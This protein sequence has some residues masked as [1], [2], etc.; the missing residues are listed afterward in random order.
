MKTPAKTAV[1]AVP[2]DITTMTGGYIYDRLLLDELR[3]AGRDMRLLQLPDGFPFPSRQDMED[4]LAALQAIDR[5]CPVIID[6]LAFGALTPEGVAR[7]AAPIVALVHHP[8]ALES[9]LPAD[10]QQHLWQT[11]RDNLRHAAQI[12]VPSPHTRAVLIERYDVPADRIHVALPGIAQPVAR[13]PVTRSGPP[14]ILSVG[15][16]HPRKGHDVL[17]DAL[18]RIADL[19]WRAEI[20]GN[21]WE[22][23]HSAALQDRIIKAGL[24]GRV[25]LA[26]R[27]APDDLERY[28][29]EATLFA[30][31]TR[32]EGYGIVFNEA[33]VHGLPIVS[34]RTG[35]VPDTVPADAG[36]LVER[37]DPAA[38]A[39]AMRSILTDQARREA[40]AMAAKRKGATLAT[41]ADTARIA[42]I[43]LD[44]AA[45]L[46]A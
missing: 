34:C 3:L 17:I 20:V 40:M 22:D 44:A 12:L 24:D 11:E 41:W 2:G 30:L 46:R 1:L 37:D 28:Y 32:Y 19:D 15:I 7:I 38:F 6:G 45:G 10:Q 39:D 5:D 26:G 31:A 23:G 43:A 8:L 27:V 16:L 25:R 42:G 21:P 4:S 18:A 35:A 9:G 33:L 36:L 14:L 13:D 29:R